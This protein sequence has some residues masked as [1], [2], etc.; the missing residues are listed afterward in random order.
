MIFAARSKTVS[1][2]D[3]SESLDSE[4]DL[5]VLLLEQSVTVPRR[6]PPVGKDTGPGYCGR[7]NR[8]D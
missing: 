2:F 3:G 6:A 5:V 4:V 7:W 1:D 8:Q